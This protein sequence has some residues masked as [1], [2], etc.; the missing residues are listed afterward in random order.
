M[1]ILILGAGALGS[2]VG[3]RLSC[4]RARVSLLSTNRAHMEAI[5]RRG[6]VIEELDERF[7]R[8]ELPAF[9]EPDAILG[10]ADWVLVTVKTYA[11]EAAVRSVLPFCSGSTLFLTLQNGVGNYE[12]I[13]QI[14]G[15][16]SN[17]VGVT[18]QG[19]TLVEPGRVR[20]GGN[21]LT[22][23]GEFTGEPSSRVRSL[24]DCFLE[25]GLKTEA[26]GNMQQLIWQKLMVNVGINAI[27]A[28]TG[29]RNGGIHS[30]PDARE[31]SRAAVEEA[32]AVAER[33]GFRFAEDVEKPFVHGAGHRPRPPYGNRRHQ[34]GCRRLRSRVGPCR[35]RQRDPH[36]TGQNTAV[37]SLNRFTPIETLLLNRILYSSI[38]RVEPTSENIRPA[39]T[40]NKGG[41]R[42]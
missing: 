41:D 7:T 20:H 18:A 31:L 35:P 15:E 9:S 19:A 16:A 14:V 40:D 32:V 11:T 42:G 34:R 26:G 10:K 1:H 38:L 6:L 33:K 8:Y 12:R 28:L 39:A 22:V 27:T 30:L 3:A 37:E 36:Q 4:T 24:V 2:L 13:S 17:L 25:A 23:L 29:I 5:Q 21:G